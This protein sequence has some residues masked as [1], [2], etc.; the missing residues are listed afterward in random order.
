MLVGRNTYQDRMM[1]P[2]CC[3]HLSFSHRIYSCLCLGVFLTGCGNQ[4]SV[5]PT[6]HRPLA[7]VVSCASAGSLTQASDADNLAS[8]PPPAILLHSDFS[9]AEGSGLHVSEGENVTYALMDGAYLVAVQQPSFLVWSLIEGE[10]RHVTNIT[11]EVMAVLVDGASTTASGLIFRYQDD[12]NF[13]RFNVATNGFYNLELM[14]HGT[15]SVLVDWTPSQAIRQIRVGTKH[16]TQSSPLSVPV[17]NTL[18]IA[19]RGESI[20]LFVN[21]IALET[22]LDG[23]FSHG[24]AALAVNTFGDGPATVCFDNLLITKNDPD[25]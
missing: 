9:A 21:G 19:L 13:Y 10:Y 18:R 3:V 14:S 11:L 24:A 15:L 16:T 23:T 1:V 22:T 2:G 7:T 17:L 20:A 6:V 4:V 8:L 5:M 25:Q 12:N